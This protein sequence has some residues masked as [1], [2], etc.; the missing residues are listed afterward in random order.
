[1][2]HEDWRYDAVP[3]IMDGMNVADWVDADIDRK[4]A[5][6]EAEEEALLWGD[7]DD[8][9]EVKQYKE[10]QKTLAAVHSVMEQ[11]KLENRMRTN[12]SR[13]A[14]VRRK[15]PVNVAEAETNLALMGVE[16]DSLAHRAKN[17]RKRADDE[18]EAADVAMGTPSY[19]KP[20]KTRSTH[21]VF[22]SD[23]SGS[24]ASKPSVK[25]AAELHKRK[26]TRKLARD[27]KSG[28]G[29]H[30]IS[31]AKPRHLFSGKRGNGSNDWR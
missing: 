22:A 6:L 28:E 9:A 20:K 31:V 3:E 10:V 19:K 21:R 23:I 14:I 1:V 25:A 30:F 29:D 13:K 16:V 27:G 2:S 7:Q 4:L 5:E 17:K 18:D 24:G 12:I 11:Q 26:S 8:E 15:N